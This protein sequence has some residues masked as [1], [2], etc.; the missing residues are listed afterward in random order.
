MALGMIN[1]TGS[2]LPWVNLLGLICGLD[3]SLLNIVYHCHPMIN[4]F[5]QLLPLGFFGFSTQLI[6]YASPNLKKPQLG[7]LDKKSLVLDSCSPQHRGN[8]LGGIPFGSS[9]FILTFPTM[10]LPT[11]LL[12]LLS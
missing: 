6:L 2:S 11:M 3:L 7:P 1:P 10:L 9:A 12:H 5:L 8:G 4:G